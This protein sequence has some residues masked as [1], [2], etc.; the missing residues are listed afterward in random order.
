[1]RDE[2]MLRERIEQAER[3][4][5]ELA[6]QVEVGEID[7][8]TAGELRR[9]YEA[10]RDDLAEQLATGTVEEGDEPQ[11][12]LS[13]SR[14]LGIGFILIAVIGVGL[15]LLA[16]TGNDTTGVEGIAEDVVT[17][18]AL[19]LADVTNEQMEV[20]VEQNPDIAPMRLALAE[21]Y[22]VDG[23]FQNALRHYMYV[24]DTM[25]EKDPTAL[26]NVGWMTYLSG[27]PDVAES[28]VEESLEVQPDGGI[29]FWYLAV[30]RFNGLGDSQGA[31]EPLRSLLAYDEVPEEIRTAAEEML[32][33]AEA[34]S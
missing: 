18:E 21:R 19:S 4:L 5:R 34:G 1:M 27:V 12:V 24:L 32:A 22:F 2:A 11:P 28:F 9:K 29:A 7:A 8:V 15:W 6:E 3:D 14:L 17:G 13:G 10:E 16:N 26:A 31:I 20:V 30:I 25:G 23:D 33:E